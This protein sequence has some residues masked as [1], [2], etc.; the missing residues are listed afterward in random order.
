MNIGLVTTWMHRG[1]A[2]VSKQYEEVLEKSNNIFVFARGGERYPK[3][4]PMWNRNNVH[5]SKPPIFQLN[6]T[7]ISEDEITSWIV[8][9]N[10]DCVIFNEQQF[11]EPLIWVK[12]L[13]VPIVAYVDYYTATSIKLFDFY[14]LLIC[15]TK[16]H[17]DC[18]KNTG[19]AIYIPWGTNITVVNGMH[20]K[21][22]ITSKTKIN[23]LFNLGHNWY[24]K[25][26]DQFILT[27]LS[28]KSLLK[29]FNFVV[30][31]QKTIKFPEKKINHFYREL[32]AIGVLTEYVG[33]FGVKEIYP[34]G[35][36]YVYLSRLDGIGLSLPEALSFGLPAI[37]PDNAPMNEFVYDKENGWYVK[38]KRY[39]RRKDDYFHDLCEIEPLSLLEVLQKIKQQ[40]TSLNILMENTLVMAEKKLNWDKNAAAL[41][42]ALEELNQT[43][44]NV[45]ESDLLNFDRKMSKRLSIKQKL[46]LC[47]K[48]ISKYI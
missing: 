8:R 42:L 3:T 37:V 15:N 18:F 20:R 19:K 40:K 2:I 41:N 1:A 21:R 43:Q 5:W 47:Y 27:I 9:N 35:D 22:K 39:F 4:D 48:N 13:G 11:W 33:D 45:N 46:S 36:I 31:T 10:I 12:K 24:R 26:F 44:S 17:F 14:D 38:V 25:G 32:K 23:L 28:N 34:K 30:F 29:D 16:R 6:G 7:P